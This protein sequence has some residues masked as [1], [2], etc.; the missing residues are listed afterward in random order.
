MPDAPEPIL[1]AAFGN[2]MAG[3]DAFGPRVAEAVRAMAIPGVEVVALGMKPAGLLDQLAGRRALCVVDAARC[4]GVPTGTLLDLDF[5]GANRPSLVHD[6]A[7]STHGLSVAD[8]IEL[9]RRLDLCPEEVRL[10][11]VAAGS[12]EVG[13]SISGE[14]LRQVSAAADRIADWARRR[15]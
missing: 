6:T 12:V 1:V 11:A 3:D 4:D 13:R 8:E 5:F 14:V 9:A 10:V 2:E 15:Q 7:L